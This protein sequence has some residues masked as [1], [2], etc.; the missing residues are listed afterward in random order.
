MSSLK[1]KSH[2][3][4]AVELDDELLDKHFNVA[5]SSQYCISTKTQECHLYFAFV[6][7]FVQIYFI[8][9][10]VSDLGPVYDSRV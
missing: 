7:I 3:K 1:W 6:H 5:H 4:T 9:C 8:F 10:L 2:V